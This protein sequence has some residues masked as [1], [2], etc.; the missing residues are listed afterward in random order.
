MSSLSPIPL[1]PPPQPTKRRKQNTYMLSLNL[2]AKKIQTFFRYHREMVLLKQIF[3]ARTHLAKKEP[4]YKVKAISEENYP[5]L[6]KI[7]YT[8][9]EK[10]NL[11]LESKVP[12]DQQDLIQDNAL[13]LHI[14]QETLLS[15]I[16][17]NNF[18]FGAFDEAGI[19]QG[20]ARCSF[21]PSH[22]ELRNLA[23]S[24]FNLPVIGNPAPKRGAGTAL[25]EEL[26]WQHKMS[27]GSGCVKLA[28]L[29][30]AIPFY[31]KLFFG[32][33]SEKDGPLEMVLTSDRVCNFLAL[34]GGSALPLSSTF[35]RCLASH[36]PSTLMA[37]KK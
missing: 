37:K 27:R 30:T 16:L 17:F 31:K 15:P 9:I 20:I 5:L 29:T 25:I 26:V 21:F 33:T 19:L 13:I 28:S 8:W 34:K 7:I 3:T 10:N 32:F 35:L 4:Q 11:L 36:I 2:A 1:T 24:P 18:I 14:L 23:T 6:L 12:F 22:V